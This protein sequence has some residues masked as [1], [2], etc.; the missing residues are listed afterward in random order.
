MSGSQVSTCSGCFVPRWL[1]YRHTL[2][3]THTHR[4]LLT[5]YT[6]S[7]ASWVRKLKIKYNICT[8]F[9]SVQLLAANNTY[10]W[11]PGGACSPSAPPGYAWVIHNDAFHKCTLKLDKIGRRTINGRAS[12]VFD[13]FCD[14][15][16]DLDLSTHDLLNLIISWFD[17]K[18][19]Q[20][21]RS[22]SVHTISIWTSLAVRPWPW[23][24]TQW[25]S[26]CHNCHIRTL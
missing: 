12:A 22:Y 24:L 25:L 9:A 13:H 8:V 19:L 7:S 6:I 15:I 11:R 20:W 14:V 26:R 10:P 5:G 1:T 16:C 3:Q 23:P 18:F 17:R 4:Q 21:F 2:K